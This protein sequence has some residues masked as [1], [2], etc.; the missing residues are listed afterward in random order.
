MQ[1]STYIRLSF[2]MALFIYNIRSNI[3]FF[4]KGRGLTMNKINKIIL[5]LVVLSL[6]V[7]S[8]GFA[9]A[10]EINDT[11]VTDSD[12]ESLDIDDSSSDSAYYPSADV[13]VYNSTDN[14]SSDDDSD[15]DHDLI[16]LAMNE[17]TDGSNDTKTNESSNLTDSNNGSSNVTGPK[18]KG[19]L[20]ITGPKIST[21]LNISAPK[22]GDPSAPGTFDDLQVEINNAESGSVLHLHRDYKG[23]YG[24]RI[25]FN[26]DLTINGHGHTLDCSNEKGCSAFYSN[27]GTIILKNLKIINGHNDNTDKGGAIYITGSAKY[28][29]IGCQFLNN[30][31]DDYG[32]A[33]YNDVDKPLTIIDCVFRGNTADDNDGG[34]I[35][36]KGE[37]NIEDSTFES[38]NA[39]IDGGAIYCKKD[40]HV[41]NSILHFNSAKGATFSQCYGGAICSQGDVYID[42]ST[43]TDNIAADFGGAVYAENIYVNTKV[44]NST[45]FFDSNTAKGNDGGALYAKKNVTL[46]NSVFTS[47]SAHQ[48]GGAVF[49]NRG[50]V[51][52]CEFGYNNATGSLGFCYGGAIR[53]IDTLYLYGSYLHHNMADDHGGAVATYWL[54]LVFDPRDSNYNQIYGNYVSDGGK[55]GDYYYEHH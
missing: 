53:A 25:Q 30:W 41:L 43:L 9:S 8:I 54:R 39:D 21:P 5:C 27:C 23:K 40:V 36:S 16:N 19:E 42:K 45:S 28:T 6:A 48:N 38:N 11:Y 17:S 10:T 7:A 50:Y 22:I 49:C 14:S 3:T 52:N 13:F 15:S 1:V 33:I 35:W 31:A 2:Y 32:G 51:K 20:N 46:Y 29:L 37:V 4:K 55:D 18:I 24:S 26:K 34:A 44:S 47:N 12:E